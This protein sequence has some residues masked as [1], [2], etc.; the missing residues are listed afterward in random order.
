VPAALSVAGAHCGERN[1]PG[2]FIDL[3]RGEHKDGLVDAGHVDLEVLVEGGQSLLE[4]VDLASDQTVHEFARGRL[5]H[6]PV[7]GDGDHVLDVDVKLVQ[8]LVERR[9][10]LVDPAKEALVDG[11]LD[12][13]RGR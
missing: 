10:G 3:A 11:R 5:E 13:R 7:E 1:R 2:R 12:S 4:R 6:S 8:G 9:G